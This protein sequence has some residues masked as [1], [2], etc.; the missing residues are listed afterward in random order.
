MSEKGSLRPVAVIHASQLERPEFSQRG[1]L[2][3]SDLDRREGI[4][5]RCAEPLRARYFDEH[6]IP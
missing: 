3:G 4:F 5:R 2:S 1:R 6:H